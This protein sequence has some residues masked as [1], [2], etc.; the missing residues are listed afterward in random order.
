MMNGEGKEKMRRCRFKFSVCR[1]GA[2][3]SLVEVRLKKG[4]FMLHACRN[5]LRVIKEGKN[6]QFIILIDDMDEA[7]EQKL[8]HELTLEAA[9]LRTSQ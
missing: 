8:R 5:C 1:N 4:T 2:A 6:E 9:G 3:N 7:A